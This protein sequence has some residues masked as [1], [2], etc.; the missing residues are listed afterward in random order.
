V[1]APSSLGAGDNGKKKVALL[2]FYF[3]YSTQAASLVIICLV[4]SIFFFAFAVS[5]SCALDQQTNTLIIVLPLVPIVVLV[6][7]LLWFALAAQRCLPTKGTPA[8]LSEQLNGGT[9]VWVDKTCADQ[10]NVAG[11]LEQGIDFFMLRCDRMVAFAS[12]S[13]TRTVEKHQLPHMPT[14]RARVL[15]LHHCPLCALADF[16]RAWCIFELATW[17]HV[18]R[19]NLDGKLFLASLDWDHFASA[20]KAAELSEEELDTMRTFSLDNMRSFK[21]SDQADVLAAIRKRWGSEEAFEAF[22][23]TQLPRVL[24]KCKRQYYG[25]VQKTLSD[26]LEKALDSA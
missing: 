4:L 22:V 24:A 7:S 1:T 9:T 16:T 25:L 10:H 18:H 3:E 2:A 20:Y 14:P 5:L 13:C 12:K 23:Q 21:A 15:S 19:D 8:F 6:L 17:C 11:F 26:T